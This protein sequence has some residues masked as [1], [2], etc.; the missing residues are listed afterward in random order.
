MV[1]SLTNHELSAAF[2]LNASSAMKHMLVLCR[3]P[4]TILTTNV[5]F[6]YFFLVVACHF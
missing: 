2:I 3:L 5:S 6:F 4:R 1:I